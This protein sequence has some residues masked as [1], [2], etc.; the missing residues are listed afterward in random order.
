M[1]IRVSQVLILGSYEISMKYFVH[2]E[3]FVVK[4]LSLFVKLI[5]ESSFL[6]EAK[7]KSVV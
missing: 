3:I 5:T 6:N 2:G 7:P 4:W 1:N